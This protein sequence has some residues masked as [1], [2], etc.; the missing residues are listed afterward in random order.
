MLQR[1]C[2]TFAERTW[3]LMRLLTCN[4][5]QCRCFVEWWA[6]ILRIRDD[7]RSFSSSFLLP[8]KVWEAQ[9]RTEG[10]WHCRA[11]CTCKIS[12]CQSYLL[13][14]L[15]GSE[16][17]KP[18]SRKVQLQGWG[19]NLGCL[20]MAVGLVTASQRLIQL[21]MAFLSLVAVVVFIRKK[22][23]LESESPSLF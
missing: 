12:F 7:Q 15:S 16:D 19:G 4:K 10:D 14:F 6:C 2:P 8:A 11:A 22:R 21:S 17:L 9:L 20:S 5:A 23:E 13:S 18:A 1:D 3:P